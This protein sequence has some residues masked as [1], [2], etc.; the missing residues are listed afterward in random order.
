[1]EVE[2]GP[3]MTIFLYKPVLVHFI[4][5]CITSALAF[6]TFSFPCASSVRY[7]A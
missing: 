5:E 4:R 7:S 6:F 1:M 3:W 2:N